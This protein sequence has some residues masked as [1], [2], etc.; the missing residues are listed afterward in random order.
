MA[1]QKEFVEE[2]CVKI[3]DLGDITYRPMMGEYLIYV[4]GKY[5][6]AIADNQVFVKPL[7]ELKPLLK[8]IIELPMYDGAKP[9]YLIEDIDDNDYL[10]QIIGTAYKILPE[11]KPKKKKQ[12]KL[13]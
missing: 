7:P 3:A 1:S 4:N 11:P 2:I 8:E 12:N 5:C 10:C 13:K 6:A 9:S